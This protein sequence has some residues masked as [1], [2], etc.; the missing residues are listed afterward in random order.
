MFDFN[1]FTCWHSWE[2]LIGYAATLNISLSLCSD[3]YYDKGYSDSGYADT[4]YGDSG[5]DTGYGDTSGKS[6]KHI[7]TF[8]QSEVVFTLGSCP[9][10]ESP[11]HF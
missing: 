4:G 10:I 8:T 5:Y 3:G 11:T 2:K 6:L 7:K 1:R 9:K